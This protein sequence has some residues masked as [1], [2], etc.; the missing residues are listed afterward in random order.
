MAETI[1]EA[2]LRR[3]PKSA[4]L[5][6]RFQH[7]FPAGVSHDMRAVT[8]FRS[9]LPV[10]R[11]HASGT[12]TATNTSTMAWA[13]PHSY[14]G[15]P[16]PL[17]C[18]RLCRRRPSGRTSGSLLRQKSS[19]ASGCVASSLCRQGALASGAEATMLAMRIA[20][21]YT[22]KSKI[23][24]WESHY[25]GWHDYVMPGTLPPLTPR[26]PSVFRRALSIRSLCSHQTCKCWSAPSPQTTTLPPSLPKV[27]ALPTAL[28]L[29]HLASWQ[30]C[31]V[32]PHNTVW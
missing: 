15:M 9:L 13:P 31:A 28:F 32:S 10:A 24:R 18:K 25:H 14:W 1:H 3:N 5:Q 16:I 21:G 4:A 2:Y 23:V 7:V 19:G 26:R 11:A 8:P 17:W 30:G 22:G 12:L 27:Q 6:S 20:R 29:S